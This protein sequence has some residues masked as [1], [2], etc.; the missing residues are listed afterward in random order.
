MSVCVTIKGKRHTLC[1]GDL[2]RI[3]TLQDRAIVP[4]LDINDTDYTEDFVDDGDE[5]CMVETL[6]GQEIFDETNQLVGV[7]DT[8]FYIR[9]RDD[10]TAET[11]ILFEDDRY[12]ILKALDLDK[13][14]E[15]LK[16]DCDSRGSDT[17]A[18]N[19]A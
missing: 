6:S 2:D 9:F 14:H 10:I 18:V 5:F 11:W 8:R 19:Q 16:L 17:L 1:A 15:W 7:I 4:P 13:R 12:T 3:L